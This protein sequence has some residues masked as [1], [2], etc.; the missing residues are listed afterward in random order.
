MVFNTDVIVTTVDDNGNTI[1]DDDHADSDEESI[2][3]HDSNIIPGNVTKIL[4]PNQLRMMMKYL[5]T[6]YP[7]MLL[8][9]LVMPQTQA[10]PRVIL[11]ANPAVG[12]IVN[13]IR[14]CQHGLVVPHKQA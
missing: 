6:T 13:D 9:Y 5:A 11:I 8:L 4:R 12:D 7:I 2:M 14:L 3:S 10:H 1:S